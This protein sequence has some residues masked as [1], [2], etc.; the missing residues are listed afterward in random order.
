MSQG[1]RLRRFRIQRAPG[2]EIDLRLAQ[3]ASE[4]DEFLVARVLA[5]VAYHGPGLELSNGVCRGDE[6]A[7]ARREYDGRLV[8]WVEVG[9]PKR[10]RLERALRNAERVAV[11]THKRAEVFLRDLKEDP[12]RRV[13]RLR[14]HELEPAALEALARTLDRD[15]RWSVDVAAA[16]LTVRVRNGEH[17]FPF[18]T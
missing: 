17:V 4:T 13:E 11:V 1:E 16:S 5:A 14:V 9:L 10:D 6:P 15:N 2:G 18:A 12:P 3:H 7:I 8:L